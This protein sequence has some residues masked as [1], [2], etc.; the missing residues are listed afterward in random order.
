[1]TTNSSLPP[2][3]AVAGAVPAQ[4]W[5]TRQ[6][7]QSPSSGPAE[8]RVG[9]EPG[10]A[11]L[12]HQLFGMPVTAPPMTLMTQAHADVGDSFTAREP[13]GVSL[14][15]RQT[16]HS[17]AAE[18]A[19]IPVVR[20]TEPRLCHPAEVP[21]ARGARI[22]SEPEGLCPSTT[23][24][25]QSANGGHD[26]S[27]RMMTNVQTTACFLSNTTVP[28]IGVEGNVEAA[29]SKVTAVAVPSDVEAPSAV[30]VAVPVGIT[31]ASAVAEAVIL[32]ITHIR[33]FVSDLLI[34]ST[35][36]VVISLGR[37][38]WKETNRP[39]WDSSLGVGLR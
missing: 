5:T 23:A 20:L 11:R 19:E 29:A 37:M 16:C 27:T 38:V 31:A 15:T 9:N 35:S 39:L 22:E 3:H 10:G 17:P 6:T 21:V 14:R 18:V 26:P 28:P 2:R 25:G 36:C 24:V 4:R 30:A 1:M 7:I 8:W 13:S 32:E 12:A 33:A 34:R